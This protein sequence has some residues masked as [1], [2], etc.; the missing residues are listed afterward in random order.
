MP[1]TSAR[2]HALER[3]TDDHSTRIRASETQLADGRVEFAEIRKDIQAATVAVVHLTNQVERALTQS[4][5]YG[6][7]VIE[8]LIFWAVPI[9]GSALIWLVVQSGQVQVRA[10][11]ITPHEV[12]HG[13]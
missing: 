6:Q 12:S 9:L 7:K 4:P 10:P 2:L 3:R 11:A 8:A 13:P 5:G 1:E